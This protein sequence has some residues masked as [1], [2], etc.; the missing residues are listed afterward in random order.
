[1]PAERETQAE[2][3]KR[4]EEENAQLEAELAQARAAAQVPSEA[5]AR[6][7]KGRGRTIAAVV[8]LV[9]AALL[10]VG[11]DK[12]LCTALETKAGFVAQPAKK[13]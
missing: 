12:D 13:N 1:M 2:R 10:A 9:V 11:K 6:S 4:L 7:K 5:A 3:L 8:I